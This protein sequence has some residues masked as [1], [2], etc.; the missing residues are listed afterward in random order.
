MLGGVLGLRIW[1]L[2]V[3]RESISVSLLLPRKTVALNLRDG[4][5]II[6]LGIREGVDLREGIVLLSTA[7]TPKRLLVL[8]RT[9]FWS[10]AICEHR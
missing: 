10:V 3:F 2:A 8:W 5:T 4:Q 6:N 7:N 1:R 9:D